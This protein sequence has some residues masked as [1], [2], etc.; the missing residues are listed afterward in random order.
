MQ[1]DTKRA[2]AEVSN[3]DGIRVLVD[4]VWPRG[5]SKEKLAID[6]WYK[7]ISPSTSLRKWF[8]HDPEKFDEFKRKY[9][10]ELQS[11]SKK[12]HVL[13]LEDLVKNNSR[14]T[15]IYGAKDKQ[16]NQAVVLKEWLDDLY[17]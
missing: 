7:E 15:L 9:I 1:V 16:H 11:N 6:H 2:F 3:D 5:V 8:D 17:T 12:Q 13:A 14:V 10:N 4:R